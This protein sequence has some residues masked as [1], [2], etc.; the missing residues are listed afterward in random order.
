MSTP[1]DW[2]EI[3]T[4]RENAGQSTHDFTNLINEMFGKTWKEINSDEMSKLKKRLQD[5][6]QVS[7]PA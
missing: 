4:L 6:A 7:Q 3:K 1:A 2:K 5:E